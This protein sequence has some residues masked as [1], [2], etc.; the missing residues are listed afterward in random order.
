MVD[1][2]EITKKIESTFEIPHDVINGEDTIVTSGYLK[3]SYFFQV[4]FV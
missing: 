4:V 2:N 1:K 3:G